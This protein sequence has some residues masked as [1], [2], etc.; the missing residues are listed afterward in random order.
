MLH[1]SVEKLVDWVYETTNDYD[2]TTPLS[3]YRMFQGEL[4]FGDVGS[5]PSS[6]P[7]DSCDWT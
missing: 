3:K 6:A 4:T 7:S 5:E 2:M 1:S